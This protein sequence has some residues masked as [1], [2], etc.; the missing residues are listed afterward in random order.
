MPEPVIP[1]RTKTAFIAVI[2]A[3]NTGKSTFINRAVGTKVSIVSPKVQTTR[4]RV[5]G[6][7]MIGDSQ[8]VFID[9]PGIFQ[10]NKRLD[11]AMVAAAWSGAEDAD[12]V[13]LLVDAARGIDDNTRR[14]VN[15]LI[16]RG[17]RCDAII[18]KTDAVKKPVLLERAAEIDETGIC[19]KIF[20]I[21]ALTGDGVDDLISALAADAPEG[22]WMFP[23]DQISDMPER[24]LAA[25]ITREQLFRQLHQELPYATTV[26]TEH[27]EERP[28]GAIA[29]DQVIFVERTSQRAIVLGK[30]GSRI[31]KLGTAA[32]TELSKLLGCKVHLKL[33]VKVREKWGEDPERYGLWGLDF[34]A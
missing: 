6:I 34:D 33:F 2:G 1:E 10:P 30:G 31:K 23:P 20:M 28:D 26:E 13:L 14:I 27:W 24:Q 32:R 11:R 25:E 22:P 21:S 7:L 12:R 8:L 29:I 3:P 4:T 16:E 18:N 5:I 17:I 19:D 9:T 15:T